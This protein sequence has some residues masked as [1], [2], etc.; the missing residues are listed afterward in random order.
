M[1]NEYKFRLSNGDW[2]EDTL[3]G[4]IP[5]LDVNGLDIDGCIASGRL[6]SK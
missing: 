4:M 2:I 1:A 5:L 6:V 3:E